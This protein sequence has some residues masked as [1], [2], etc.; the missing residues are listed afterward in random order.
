M[1]TRG[2]QLNRVSMVS[3]Q[4]PGGLSAYFESLNRQKKSIALD[5]K[6]PKGVE[7]MYRLAARSDVFVQNFRK[8]VAERLGLGYEDLVKHNP[9]IVYGAATGY[10]PKG[11]DASKPAYALAGEARSGSLWWGG[12]DD[13]LPYNIGGIADQMAGIMLSYGVLGALVAREK[14]GIGQKVDA[15]HLGGRMWLGGNRYGMALITKNAPQR[16]DRTL[17]R[18]P[19]WNF[20]ECKDG[21]WIALS[22]NQTDRYWP[23]LCKA[24][25]RPDLIED[26][27]FDNM[28]AF[29]DHRKELIETLDAIFATKTQHEWEKVLSEAEGIIW[30]CVQDVF[31]LPDDP[32]VIA[33]NYIVDFDHPVL[34]ASKWLQTP[35]GYSKTPLST[36]KMAPALGEDTEEFLI[37]TLGYTRDDIGVLRDERAI[38]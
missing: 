36:R 30:E 35:V 34:G 2:R 23:F 7:V 37:D 20:Y 24:L 18:N 32:Q 33:N 25:S 5:L 11:P 27:R 31:D 28:Q 19:L 16:Q 14:F 22:M 21:R 38:L 10:G 3:S 6:N 9:K 26:K 17:A 1:G 29:V 15:S 8:G 4:L 13:G 12:P